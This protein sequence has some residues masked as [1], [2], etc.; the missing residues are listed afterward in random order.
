MLVVHG[1]GRLEDR[2]V[3]NLPDYLQAGDAVVFNETRV[4]PAALKGVRRARNAAGHNVPI[5]INLTERLGEDTWQALARPGKRLKIDDQI[6]ISDSLTAGVSEKLETGEIVL[7][8]NVSGTMLDQAVESDGAMPLPPYIARRRAADTQDRTDYQTVFAGDQPGSVAAPTAGLHFTPE[9]LKAIDDTGA[10]RAQVTLHVGLGTFAP[11]KDDQ[12]EQHTLHEEWR[13]LSEPVAAHLNSV[14]A[15]G[16]RIIPVG[17]TALRTLE[18]CC[19][20]TGALFSATGP[21]DIFIKPG[22]P[23]RA[24]DMLMTNFHLPKSTLFMLVCALMGTDVMQAAYAHA[25]K[26]EYRFYS[27]GDACLLIP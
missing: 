18:S 24:A 17:T 15:G 26:E 9:L 25:V 27:Y 7:V 2:T 11:V 10:Q 1:D 21:T 19:D 6:D 16:G 20:E 8:F 5:D 14:R 3:K 22:D 23:I 13:H 12:L 4:I